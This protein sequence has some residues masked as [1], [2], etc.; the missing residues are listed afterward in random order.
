MI[1]DALAAFAVLG[2]GVCTRAFHGFIVFA[3]HIFI[4][5]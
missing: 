3:W 4:L 5:P 2:T 1:R